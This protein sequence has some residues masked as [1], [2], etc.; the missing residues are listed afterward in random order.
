MSPTS[1]PTPKPEDKNSPDTIT[2]DDAG[3]TI[4]TIEKTKE[5]DNTENDVSVITTNGKMLLS[6]M[7]KANTTIMAY[8][9]IDY[10]VDS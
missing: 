2:L 3:E 5:T 6:L 4:E 7:K 1:C 9:K 10:F 8:C